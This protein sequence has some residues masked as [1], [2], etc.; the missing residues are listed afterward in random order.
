MK[1]LLTILLA[2]FSLIACQK[3]KKVHRV[4]YNPP[5]KV[6]N[7][8]SLCM[9]VDTHDS[10][11]VTINY[12]DYIDGTVNYFGM[13]S[14]IVKMNDKAEKLCEKIEDKQLRDSIVYQIKKVSSML[15]EDRWRIGRFFDS[16][17]VDID[18]LE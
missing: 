9:I 11:D 12:Y 4:A 15:L 16:D 13:V 6:E 3:T 5:S 2:L 7:R 8:D 14:D 17:N 1:K 18:F 10:L